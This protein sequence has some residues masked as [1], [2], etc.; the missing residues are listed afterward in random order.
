M[1][2]PEQVEEFSETEGSGLTSAQLWFH[3]RRYPYLLA[4]IATA[5]IVVVALYWIFRSVESVLFPVLLSMLIAYLIDPAIDRLEERGWS[6]TTAIGVF[7]VFI[8]GFFAVL[9]LFLYPTIAHAI[10][11]VVEGAPKLL[12]MVRVQ[13]IPW[14][15]AQTNYKLPDT[16]SKALT[17]YGDTIQ[18]QAPKILTGATEGALEAWKRTGILV[19]S[20]LNI[21][22]IPIFT[23]YF[24]RDFDKMRLGLV[25]YLPV[26]NRDWF[27]ER[28]RRMDE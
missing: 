26:N 24:L 11:K 28:F 16:L 8:L 15:E 22:M 18:A 27:I 1:E 14:F 23:F 6:R 13:A 20:L 25:D 2:K 10:G 19:A 9:S 5:A 21:V 4:K 12:E 17:E 7:L 3:Y